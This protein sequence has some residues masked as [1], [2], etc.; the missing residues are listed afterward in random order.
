MPCLWGYGEIA[1]TPE[2]AP[3]AKRRIL[4]L[5]AR[6]RRLSPNPISTKKDRVNALSFLVEK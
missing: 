2:G 5:L 3:S 4:R 6:T 1:E